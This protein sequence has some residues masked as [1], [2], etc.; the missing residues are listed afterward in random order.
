MIK[1]YIQERGSWLL[2]LAGI[3]LVI[4]FVAYVDA[5][6]PFLPILYIVLLNV[7]VCTLFVFLRYQRE[8]RFYR[9]IESWDEVYDLEMF[10]EA[11]S[12]FENIVQEAVT[13]QTERYRK[14]SSVN[15]HLLEQEK[16]DL[17]AWI[18]EV[19]TP[20]TAMQLMIERLPDETLQSQLMFEWLRIHHLLDQQL[21]QK[22][23]PF[24]RND[25][26]IENTALE[27]VLN[28]EIRAL[29][30][31]C[32]SKGIGFDVSLEVEEVLT[33]GKWLGFMLR[34]LLTNAVKYSEASDITVMSHEAD[35]HAVLVIEDQGKGIEP[36]DLPRI[37]DK[38][39]TSVLGRQEGAATGMGLY[40]T[41]QVA[42]PLLIRIEVDSAPGAGAKFILVFP[43]ENDFVS[44]S[45]T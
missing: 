30:S 10:R 17:L 34:Q 13:S 23:I 5:S 16:D 6:I 40:L 26:F 12:P 27:P 14:E 15:Y 19:K 4:L 29:K 1:K 18:H 32:I 36:K 28:R 33:D 7:L 2:L 20:L 37:F 42:E 35:G 9:T 39:F 31:W 21:H 45:G 41:K 38:G 25:L 24:M 3:Q 8:T 22:R 43:K 11:G 44:I